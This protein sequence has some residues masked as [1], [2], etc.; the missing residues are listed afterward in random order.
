MIR[1][2]PPKSHEEEYMK[3]NEHV[4][5]TLVCND[6]DYTDRFTAILG[7]KSTQVCG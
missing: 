4:G 3:V 7:T 5:T 2:R 1:L 6:L